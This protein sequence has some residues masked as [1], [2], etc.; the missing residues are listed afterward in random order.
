MKVQPKT[1]DQARMP[2]DLFSVTL[3]CL[4]SL[5]KK[6]EDFFI[7]REYFAGLK[8]T[9]CQT[10]CTTK[11]PGLGKNA[12]ESILKCLRLSPLSLERQEDFS[13]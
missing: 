7:Q 3:G 13:S 11:D 8:Y 2:K 1:K 6:Q 5:L 10:S 4:R 9:E 12:T